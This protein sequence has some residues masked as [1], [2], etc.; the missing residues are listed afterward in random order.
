[1]ISFFCMSSKEKDIFVSSAMVG[2]ISEKLGVKQTL[3]LREVPAFADQYPN[4]QFSTNMPQVLLSYRRAVHEDMITDGEVV[5]INTWLHQL[6]D[7]FVGT[8]SLETIINVT[9]NCIAA[10]GLRKRI[11]LQDVFESSVEQEPKKLVSDRLATICITSHALESID[12]KLINQVVS[13]MSR[14]DFVMHAGEKNKSVNCYST[15]TSSEFAAYMK[16]CDGIITT[17]QYTLLPFFRTAKDKELFLLDDDSIEIFEKAKL[18]QYKSESISTLISDLR[19][20]TS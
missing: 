6:R 19:S 3:F 18:H 10:L 13:A 8:T 1:M 17:H 20:L 16:R 15:K 7:N 5:L 4:V 14:Y 2:A 12:A 9:K 11:T